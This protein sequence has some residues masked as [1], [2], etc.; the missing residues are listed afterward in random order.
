[1]TKFV[2]FS[3]MV[4]LALVIPEST[5]ARESTTYVGEGRYLG[6]DRTSSDTAVIRQRNQ[7][8]T[9]RRQDRNRSEERYQESERQER[10]YERNDSNRLY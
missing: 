3:A 10:S 9:E 2:V 5:Q 8:Q 4:S 1:M 7:E 6:Q